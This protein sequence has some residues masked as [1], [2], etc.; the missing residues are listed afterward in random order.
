MRVAGR[1][2]RGLATARLRVLSARV[3]RAVRGGRLD[4]AL[5]LARRA[6]A[7]AD[8]Q[9]D[10]LA[11]WQW[12]GTLHNTAGWVALEC[13]DLTAAEAALTRSLRIEESID[14]RSAETALRLSNLAAV[15]AHRGELDRAA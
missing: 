7:L 3:D 4:A 10:D 9:P 1:L 8:R 12:R 5:V 2:R 15:S 13:G 6:C 11:A 14:P